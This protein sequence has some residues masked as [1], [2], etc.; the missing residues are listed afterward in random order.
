[1][2]VGLWDGFAVGL[3]A[4]LD[5]LASSW[6]HESEWSSVFL[7]GP[8]PVTPPSSLSFAAFGPGSLDFYTAAQ[9]GGSGGFFRL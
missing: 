2:F 4:A 5:L 8:L 6:G 9:V 7:P 3:K 1:L